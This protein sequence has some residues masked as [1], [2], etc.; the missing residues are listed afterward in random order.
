MHA[1]PSTADDV[2]SRHRATL[3]SAVEALPNDGEVRRLREKLSRSL[4]RG[5][6]SPEEDE[7]IRRVYARYLHVR[8]ALHNTLAQLEPLA[9]KRWTPTTKTEAL[10]AFLLAW[11][12]GCML[13]RA[14]RYLVR[15]FHG[16]KRLRTLLNQSEPR[17]GIPA[18]TLDQIH[19]AATRP[20][21]VMRYLRAARF[22]REHRGELESLRT[23]ARHAP[24]LDLLDAETPFVETQTRQLARDV[25][26]R[27]WGR[28]R[29]TPALSYRRVMRGI[30][31]ASGR[32]IAE[33]RNPFHRKRVNRRVRH[34]L[35]SLIEP[36]DIL[37]TRHDDAL[38]NLF[39][40]GFWPHAAF[41][42][43]HQHQRNALGVT[44][45]P[46]R[47]ARCHPPLCVLEAKKDGVRFRSLR[48]T[49]RVDAFVLLRPSG[50]DDTLRRRAVERAMSHEG[51]LYDFEF[52]FTRADR[53][54]CTEV[55]YRAYG[56]LGAFQFS[57]HKRAG[58]HTLSAEDLIR[59][60]LESK[61]FEV[62]LLYGIQ[63]NRTFH[64][65][66]ARTMLLRS[67]P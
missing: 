2:F 17:F 29:E 36:G 25:F 66:R 59:Q 3:L 65:Q 54:V 46:A 61:A 6:F 5:W 43:G 4:A 55:P 50:M 53:L 58:R 21:T 30:F 40:P 67:L 26:R 12:A 62:V 52:D 44:P 33:M 22:A 60:A 27:R 32:A 41:V 8:V 56:G 13:M 11:L 31:E 7:E 20:A 38:S 47:A 14:A 28:L 23:D 64:G 48:E 45:D 39:L 24:M 1:P 34:L 63:G 49:L 18:D 57:L 19:R 42:I 16:D 35:S 51:K 10:Q 9:P 37:V 15:E